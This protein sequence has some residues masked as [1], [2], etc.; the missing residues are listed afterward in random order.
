MWFKAGVKEKKRRYI[1]LKKN[2][3]YADRHRKGG[4]LS[5]PERTGIAG[6]S[7]RKNS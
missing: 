5:Y 4:A 1:L 6:E 3:A 2:N 7:M